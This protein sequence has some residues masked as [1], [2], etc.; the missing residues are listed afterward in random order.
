MRKHEKPT[1]NLSP[2]S[3]FPLEKPTGHELVYFFVASYGTTNI[4]DA[5]TDKTSS[6]TVTAHLFDTY[7]IVLP[8]VSWP[9][10]QSFFQV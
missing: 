4:S 2:Y 6:T 9:S 8:I 7:S 1:N 3:R 5:E 10:K